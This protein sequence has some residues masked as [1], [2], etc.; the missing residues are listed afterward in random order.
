MPFFSPHQ[1]TKY[2]DPVF[3]DNCDNKYRKQVYFQLPK[4]HL[5]VV[6]LQLKKNKRFD[7]LKKK[8]I[9]NTK[10]WVCVAAVHHPNGKVCVCGGGGGCGPIFNYEHLL[11]QSVNI[12]MFLLFLLFCTFTSLKQIWKSS[13]YLSEVSLNSSQDLMGSVQIMA[14]PSF[15]TV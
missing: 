7:R 15:N 10:K 9:K 11:L 3:E 1:Y 4:R 2:S 13:F 8:I 5:Q 14:E 12:F 6:Y